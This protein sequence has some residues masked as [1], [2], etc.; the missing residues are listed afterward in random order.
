M[1][2]MGSWFSDKPE[3]ASMYSGSSG[4][5]YPVYLS[6]KNPLE[7][8]WQEFLEDGQ[9][10]GKWK[11][12]DAKGNRIPPGR[13]DPAPYREY[14]QK[15]GYDG[16]TFPPSE[17][18]DGSDHRVYVAFDPA[19]IKS[20][21]GNNGQ[22]DPTN[23]DIRFMPDSPGEHLDEFKGDTLKKAMRKPGWAILTANRESVGAPD[24]PDNI[25]A[26]EALE[27]EL[28]ERKLPYRV[29]ARSYKGQDQGKNFLITGVSENTALK[30]GRKYGQESVLT[31]KG[32]VYQDGSYN[33]LR[34]N[35]TT[36]G[37]EA[38]AKDGYTVLPDGTPFSADVNFSKRL[39]P[40][41]RGT[42][43]YKEMAKYLTPEERDKVR[44]DTARRTTGLAALSVPEGRGRSAVLE[45]IAARAQAIKNAELSSLR[46]DKP[47]AQPTLENEKTPESENPF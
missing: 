9:A 7:T 39:Q 31:P 6:L 22:F 2:Q 32:Y 25:S 33:P 28:Q 12:K 35:G 16:L 14:L 26:N 15:H 36:V 47:G 43:S 3:G 38:L 18:I 20:A 45:R 24:H 4:A 21:I 34:V 11:P 27:K 17:K 30:L 23:S 10:F 37:D 19:Q 41:V 13:F 40:D 1:D 8:T 46:A 5:V 29:V 42:T 44:S